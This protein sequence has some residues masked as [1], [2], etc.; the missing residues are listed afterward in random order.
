[1]TSKHASL[2]V[3]A[4]SGPVE[5][6]TAPTVEQS[7]APPSARK[8]TDHPAGSAGG[9]TPAAVVAAKV[10]ARLNE[11]ATAPVLVIHARKRVTVGVT[12]ASVIE[13]ARITV[14]PVA[15]RPSAAFAVPAGGAARSL[16]TSTVFATTA[17]SVSMTSSETAGL[18]TELARSVSE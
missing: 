5:V 6:I 7:F 2:A 8:A 10:A 12:A 16:V 14:A 1:M 4:A 13:L 3:P 18:K 11:S 9:V 15:P 17:E